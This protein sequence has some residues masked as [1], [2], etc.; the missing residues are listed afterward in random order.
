M[1]SCCNKVVERTDANRIILDMQINSNEWNY[2]NLPN[3]NY[4]IGTFD[5][6][7]I[8]KAI[9]DNGTVLVYRELDWGSKNAVQQILP[10][11]RH[12]EYLLDESTQTWGLYTE[13]VDYEYGVGFVNIFYTASDFEYE[14]DNSIVPETM[15]FRLVITW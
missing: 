14:V 1:A 5:V 12:H 3:N 11:S 9:Y 8:T 7:E 2:S 13:T 4:F 6:P 10:Y 15:H